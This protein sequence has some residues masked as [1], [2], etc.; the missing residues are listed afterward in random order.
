M[1]MSNIIRHIVE[2]KKLLLAWQA[3]D[4]SKNRTRWAVGLVAREGD[5]YLLAYFDAEEFLRYNDG[6]LAEVKALGF[7]GYPA[8][9]YKT[10]THTSG[11]LDAF[12]RR[13]PPRNRADFN[14]YRE[15]FRISNSLPISDFALLGITEAKLPSDGFSLVDPIE[16]LNAERELFFEI[17]GYRHYARALSA[18]L[19]VGD[20]VEFLP[21]PTNPKDR[22]AVMLRRRGETLGYVNRHQARAFLVWIAQKRVTAEVERLNGDADR[23]RAFVFARV[24]AE[25]KSI[26]A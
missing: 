10:K 16:D 11:V 22:N 9:N 3:P 2:P 15:Q 8:F 19:M 6:T 13:L 24:H 17:A 4:S 26:A 14:Q 1:T 23:P 7:E 12:L 21:E 5:S 25:N 18:Q 20:S